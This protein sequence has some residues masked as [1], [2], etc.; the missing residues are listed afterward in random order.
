MQSSLSIDLSRYTTAN[1]HEQQS[2]KVHPLPANL[3]AKRLPVVGERGQAWLSSTSA[4]FDFQ[5]LH[6]HP[7]LTPTRESATAH[8]VACQAVVSC[9]EAVA[10]SRADRLLLQ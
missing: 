5:L 9:A 2:R 3:L 10:L 8:E 6:G 4:C 7:S 1:L